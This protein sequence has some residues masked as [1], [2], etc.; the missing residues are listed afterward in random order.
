MDE[1]AFL[2]DDL[3]FPLTTETPEFSLDEFQWDL[4]EIVESNGVGGR[5]AAAFV[6]VPG[7]ARVAIFIPGA[8][9]VVSFTPG[10]VNSK[11]TS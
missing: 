8:A 6:H 10:Q 7:A 9:D 11:V 4:S 5:V 3:T 1:T 2:L